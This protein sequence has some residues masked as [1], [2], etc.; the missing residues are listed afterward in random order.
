MSDRNRREFLGLSAFGVAGLLS[1][2]S[3]GHARSILAALTANASAPPEADLIV[4]NAKVYTMDPAL[5]RAEAFAVSAGRITA[6]GTSADIRGL[7]G[8]RTQM[9]DAKQMTV[10]PG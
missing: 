6:V 5:A 9:F 3:I 10:V 8:R 1:R 2:P 7:S 4:H